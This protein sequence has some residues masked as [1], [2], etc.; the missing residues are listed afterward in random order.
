MNVKDREIVVHTNIVSV[1]ECIGTK[2]EGKANYCLRHV[3]GKGGKQ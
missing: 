2:K 3:V 1:N